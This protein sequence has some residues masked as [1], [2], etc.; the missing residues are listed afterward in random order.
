MLGEP[1]GQLAQRVKVE[2]QQLN[3]SEDT[4]LEL[5]QAVKV[6]ANQVQLVQVQ[7][8]HRLPLGRG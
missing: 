7:G 1:P 5:R 6:C 2:R 3:V 8:K 4:G